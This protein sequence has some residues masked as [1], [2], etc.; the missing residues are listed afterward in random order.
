MKDRR[1]SESSSGL[2]TGWFPELEAPPGS[3]PGDLGDAASDPGRVAL[4]AKRRKTL[5]WVPRW[6]R[7]VGLQVTV[8]AS[9]DVDQDA[10]SKYDAIVVEAGV[11]L[12]RGKALYDW[13]AKCGDSE[14]VSRLFVL[15]A[16]RRELERAKDVG[17]IEALAPS[18]DWELLARRLARHV[19]HVRDRQSL[20]ACQA[21]LRDMRGFADT[22]RD[23]L[24]SENT[25]EPISG[26]PNRDA[27]HGIVERSLLTADAGTRV[28]VLVVGFSRFGLVVD[29]LGETEARRLV[30]VVGQRLAECLSVPMPTDDAQRLQASVI[31]NLGQTRFGAMLS[32]T[33]ATDDV[34]TAFRQHLMTTLEQPT[35]VGGKMMNLSACLGI[36]IY[37]DDTD[38][39]DQLIQ[40]ADDAMRK[41]ESQG[42]GFH[43]HALRDLDRE[44]SARLQME[45]DLYTALQDERLQLH[46][47]P[48]VRF[49][50][51]K[52]V[53]AEAL[54]R[55][56]HTDGT[57]ISPEEF[58]P[59]AEESS[60]IHR[61]GEWVIDRAF[62][63]IQEWTGRGV[64][65]PVICVNVARGQLLTDQF[66]DYLGESLRHYDVDPS[67]L[68]LEISERGVLSR[69]SDLQDRMN[70]LKSLGVSLS[71]DDFGTGDSAIDYLRTLPIDAL[72]IDKSYT[73]DL[74]APGRPG[75]FLGAILA[76]AT[77]L[78]VRTVV[79]GVETK[80]EL[81]L[82]VPLGCHAFQGFVHSQ[83][84]DP[85]RFVRLLD[86]EDMPS[87]D[88]V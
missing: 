61:L 41:A 47:Q 87:G 81:D 74:G 1:A 9:D 84:L 88:L 15:C 82:L 68:E 5:E 25:L 8:V 35:A 43:Y 33:G 48:I 32:W 49:S 58:I 36:A 72:K 18:Q 6:C 63:D 37:P 14:I 3:R 40:R 11:K 64:D 30:K 26:L 50:D 73:R 39:A 71:V 4:F 53:A 29:A 10:L 83:A 22:A 67:R 12:R 55:W 62:K 60:L 46:Y 19:A 80:D 28:A 86:R 69:G 52:I 70:A 54:I 42:G 59:V 23:R 75:R 57:S 51:R 56:N 17:G 77:A 7:S 79:E 24:A 34:L 85:S 38:D 21:R 20:D 13:L 66:V 76:L 16:S 44:S 78:D 27:F 45:H 31:A 2:L 65:V